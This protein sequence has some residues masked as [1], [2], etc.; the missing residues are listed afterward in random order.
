[1]TVLTAILVVAAAG[2]PRGPV[3]RPPRANRMRSGHAPTPF[4]AAQ[5]R[6][7][8]RAGAWRLYRVAAVGHPASYRRLRFERASPAGAVVVST[9]T[10]LQGR[11]YGEQR[12]VKA[13]WKALQSHASFPARA[14]DI[15]TERRV[16]PAGAFECWR[17]EVVGRV[18]GRREVRR[19][20]FAK[21]LPGPP[22]DLERRIDGRVVLRMVLLRAGQGES[23]LHPRPRP[24]PRP[25]M[26]PAARPA[27]RPR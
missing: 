17:Y 6:D 13:L 4:S 5:I 2:C 19:F 16:T 21:K 12:G 10:D 20:W 22:V 24:A 1:M 3:D 23:V 26:R 14:T 15:R 25:A 18:A 11:P 27:M 7:G 8:C 9:M